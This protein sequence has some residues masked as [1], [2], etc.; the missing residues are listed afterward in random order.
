MSLHRSGFVT[1]LLELK[2]CCLVLRI[3]F[4]MMMMIAPNS[5]ARKVGKETGEVK[6]NICDDDDDCP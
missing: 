5:R 6:E 2:K 4:V 3:I 1:R